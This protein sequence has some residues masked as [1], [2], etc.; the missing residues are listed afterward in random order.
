MPGSR[1]TTTSMSAEL[2]V[3]SSKARAA[4]L[5]QLDDPH[6]Q[7]LGKVEQPEGSIC[8]PMYS[9][10]LDIIHHHVVSWIHMRTGQQ[11]FYSIAYDGLPDAQHILEHVF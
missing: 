7:V 9:P 2:I 11:N 1:Q 4:A 3:E 6:E 8:P 10:G 5:F